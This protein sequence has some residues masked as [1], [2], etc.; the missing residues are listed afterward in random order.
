MHRKEWGEWL[1][2][3]SKQSTGR[4]EKVIS[5]TGGMLGLLLVS[6][7][8]HHFLDGG[9]AALVVAS[10]GAT[11][12]LV[13]GIPHGPVSQP[14]P[15]VA[16]NVVSAVVGVT[17]AQ[18]IPGVVLASAVAV[19]IAIWI[20]YELGCLHPPGGATAL[21]AVIGGEQIGELGYGY[22]VTPVLLN[23]GLIVAAAVV[24]NLFFPGEDIRLV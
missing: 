1:G 12:V 22:V 20:M 21:T 15:V 4:K 19:G 23:V 18:W 13:F 6:G 2:I 3:Q 10:M 24:F 17:C 16:G 8:S 7:V 14:W 9:E 5:A 11:A